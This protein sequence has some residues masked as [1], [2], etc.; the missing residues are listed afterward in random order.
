M[1]E[2]REGTA[3]VSNPREPYVHSGGKQD[4]GSGIEKP[5]YDDRQIS[6][7]ST[8]ELAA[9]R[10]GPGTSDAGPRRVSQAEREGVPLDTNT[11]AASP[12]VSENQWSRRA[13]SGWSI[14]RMSESVATPKI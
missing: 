10:G 4:P 2:E 9:E 12:M 14:R 7:K 5:P 3:Q 11:D 6:G 8:E 13:T 1:T